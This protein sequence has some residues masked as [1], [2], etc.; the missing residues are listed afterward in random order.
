MFHFQME[1]FFHPDKEDA[2]AEFLENPNL[3]DRLSIAGEDGLDHFE[4]LDADDSKLSFLEDV[5]GYRVD[6]IDVA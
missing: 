5:C 2:A 1:S 6:S 4:S 3:A